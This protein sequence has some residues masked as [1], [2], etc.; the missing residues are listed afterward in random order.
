[1]SFSIESALETMVS[2]VAALAP[3]HVPEIR[4]R[5]WSY[6]RD[7]LDARWIFSV[8]SYVD[9]FET[10]PASTTGASHAI[11][12]VNGTAASHTCLLLPGVNAGDEVIILP[13]SFV[14]TANTVSYC[15]AVAHFADSDEAT[16]GLDPKQLKVHL[17]RKGTVCDG[18]FVNLETGRRIA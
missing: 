13:L 5:D 16:L 7:C 11:A 2:V 10:T 4:G 6:V 14:A 17:A 1:M 12:T 18:S 3:L 8:G 15:G 9:Q